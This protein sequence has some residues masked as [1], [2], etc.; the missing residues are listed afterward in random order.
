M[1]HATLIANWL[2]HPLFGKGYQFWSGAGSDISE[3]TLLGIALGAWKHVN[4]AVPWCV[5]FG[6]HPTADGLH[7][8]C[9]RHHP[10]LPSRRLSL[11]EIHARH[12]EHQ[13]DDR[14]K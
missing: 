11:D 9:R 8:L 7:K 4:C 2:F 6:R 1:I 5:R 10:D 12:R 14:K 13:R 3:L